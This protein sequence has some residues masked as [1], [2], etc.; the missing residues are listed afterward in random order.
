M[1]I[2]IAGYPDFRDAMSMEK[3]LIC[4]II[5]ILKEIESGGVLGEIARRQGIS[6]GTID[7]CKAKYG[8]MEVSEAQC[9]RSLE[10]E[11]SEA[12]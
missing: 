2:E 1:L 9:L 4:Q 5:G 7:R 10:E 11:P 3:R 12:R 8:G 6:E